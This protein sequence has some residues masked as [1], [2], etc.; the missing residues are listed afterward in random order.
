MLTIK[1]LLA[2]AT[3]SWCS[4]DKEVCEVELDNGTTVCLCWPDLK[5]TIRMQM[6]TTPTTGTP[7]EP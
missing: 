3:C 4:K 1:K 5:R 6:L 2:N 7:K